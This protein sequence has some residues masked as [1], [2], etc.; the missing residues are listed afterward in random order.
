MLGRLGRIALA[1]ATLVVAFLVANQF[2]ESLSPEVSAF[3][4][5]GR[6]PSLHEDRG[7]AFL[8]GMAAPIDKDP[9]VFGVAFAREMLEA[10]RKKRRV[11]DHPEMLQVKGADELF[12][13]PFKEDCVAKFRA[14]PESAN[15]LAADNAALLRR[16]HE[17]Y[18]EADISEAIDAEAVLGVVGYPYAGLAARLQLIVLSQVA[19]M[20]AQGDTDGALAA[21][22]ADEAFSRR[23]LS[24][25][26]LM[27][28][29]FVASAMVNRDLMMAR[30]IARTAAT[31]SPRQRDLLLQLSSPLTAKEIA[32]GSIF[33]AEAAGLRY[34]LERGIGDRVE[35]REMTDASPAVSHFMSLTVL[36]NA[37]L[38]VA[39]PLF[40]AM[41]RLDSTDSRGI[42]AGLDKLRG[43]FERARTPAITWVYNPGGRMFVAYY[44]GD[45]ALA[46]ATYV[47]RLRDADAFSQ[48]VCTAIDLRVNAV[49]RQD[50]EGFLASSPNR[51]CRDPYTG[52]PMRWDAE[53]GV[54]WFKAMDPK[55]VE[56]WGGHGE[57]VELAPY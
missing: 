39:Y 2:D 3:Y 37:S 5:S 18:K 50:V 21:L 46:W 35:M 49:A 31:L 16:Y 7:Y 53:K 14:R 23:W 51:R 20:A 47:V 25:G 36:R 8:L 48:L 4:E 54:L 15:D 11:P 22:E 41:E 27:I 57:R 34:N 33:R 43:D 30:Q 40:A 10:A 29:K 28:S 26:R 24:Q 55:N 19:A 12:C 52:R 32:L 9:R 44:L 45:N 56:R 17:L 42:A 6:F 38:N 13:V 1:G